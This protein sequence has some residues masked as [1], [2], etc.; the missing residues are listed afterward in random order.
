MDSK[1]ERKSSTATERERGVSDVLAFT[2]T[3]AIIITGVGLVSTVALEPIT[4]FTDRQETVNSERGFQN[5]AST[6]DGLHLHGDTYG[7]F[8]LVP[9]DGEL[10]LGR[11]QVGGLAG[12]GLAF[13]DRPGDDDLEQPFKQLNNSIEATDFG[14]V[15]SVSFLQVKTNT[16]V[17]RLEDGSTVGY[18]AGAVFRS[19]AAGLSYDPAIE[20]R[21][22]DGGGLEAYVSIVNLLPAGNI[23]VAINEFEQNLAIGPTEIPAGTPV[24][25]NNRFAKF[26]VERSTVAQVSNQTDADFSISPRPLI[27]NESWLEFFEQ[28]AQQYP[29][30]SVPTDPVLGPLPTCDCDRVTIRIVEVELSQLE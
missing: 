1:H 23:T 17:N 18:E 20:F 5:A 6:I 9:G 30:V 29:E 15:G 24:T 7:Q 16:L 10:F 26:E 12:E 25:A 19:D 21:R 22:L 28:K 2:L 27:G 3:F 13:F 11:Q 8:D 4:D 14:S